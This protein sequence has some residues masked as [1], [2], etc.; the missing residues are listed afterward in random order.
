MATFITCVNSLRVYRPFWFSIRLLAPTFF[1]AKSRAVQIYVVLLHLLVT[2]MF[3]VHLLLGLLLQPT[4]DEMFKNLTMSITCMACS[5]K[6]IVHLF[7]LSDIVEIEA[8]LERFNTFVISEE[9]QGFY[10]NNLSRSIQLIY[11]CIQISYIFIYLMFLLTLILHI[12][13]EQRELLYSAWLPFDW[14]KNAIFYTLAVSYQTVCLFLEGFQ[15]LTND[16]YTPLTLCFLAGHVHLLV[17]RLKQLGYQELK[18]AREL[19]QHAQLLTYIEQHRLLMRLHQLI[20]ETISHVQLI[21]LICCGATLCLIVYYV[22]FYVRDIVEFSYY[23]IYF[24]VI[25]IQLFP[26]CYYASVVAEEIQNLPYAIFSGKWYG[27]SVDYRRNVLIFSQL[28]LGKTG[29]DRVMKAGGIIELNLNAFF[30]T[31][32]MAYSLFAVVLRSRDV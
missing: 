16:S 31:L 21:Q 11:R 17:M 27:E 2:I 18:D 1:G 19:N 30:A 22:L 9:E 8:L 32:K 7:H 12:R 20:R 24:A 14:Q 6:H 10:H 3:P 13:G 4:P 23:I 15:G 26:G 28:T 29:K 25:C 5:L